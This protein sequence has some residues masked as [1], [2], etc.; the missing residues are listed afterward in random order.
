MSRF[1]FDRL[2]VSHHAISYDLGDFNLP[3]G[4]SGATFAGR[5]VLVHKAEVAPIECVVRGYLAGSRLERVPRIRP[6]LRRETA[7]RIE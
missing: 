4:V 1:W 6:S 3:A 7:L 5:S 2:D